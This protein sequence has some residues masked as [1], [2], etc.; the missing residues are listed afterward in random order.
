MT[1]ARQTDNDTYSA[2][3]VDIAL[4]S[5]YLEVQLTIFSPKNFQSWNPSDTTNPYCRTVSEVPCKSASSLAVAIV[6]TEY[7]VKISKKARILELKRRYLKITIMTPNTPYPSRKIRC[8]CA[9]TSQKTTKKIRSIRRIQGRP[10]RRIQAMEI[11]YSGRYRTWSL[12]QETP[13]TP[14][15]EE[16]AQKCGKV[17][18]WETAKYGKIWYDEDVHDLKS[19]ETEFPAIVFNDNLT[20][21]ETLFCEPTIS[22]LNNNEI[23]FRISFDES[24]D[25]DYIVVFDNNSFS[26][27]IISA[28][29]LKTD[30]ENDIEKV[31]VPSFPLPEPKVS[32]FDDLDFFRDFENEFSAIVYND[33]LTSKS[34]FLSKPTLK[35]QQIDEFNLKNETSLSEYDEVEQNVL[36]F[37]DLFPFN[38]IYPDDLMSGKDNDDNKID[39]IQ[40]SEGNENTQG[41]NNLLEGS[42]D[43]INKI[44]NE[45]S[46]IMEL[47][48]NIM[49][50]NYLVNGMLLNLIKN[51]YVPFGIPFDPKRYYK[52]GDCTRMLQRPMY[53]CFTLLNLEKLVSKNGYGVLDMGLPPRDLSTGMLK[54]KVYSLAELGGDYLILEGI[55]EFFSTFR[56]GE[57]VLDLD[58]T[59][60]Y[61]FRI[62]RARRSMSGGKFIC[63]L[64]IKYNKGNWRQLDSGQLGRELRRRSLLLGGVRHLRRFAAGRKSGALILGGQF[65]ARLA[66]H[67]GLLTE[68][69]LQG[70]AE[71][72]PVA[73][74]SGD[75]DEEM[76]QA[77]TPPPRTQGKRIFRLEEETVTSLSWMMD[78]AGVTYTRYSESP[79][80]YQRRVVRKRNDEPTTFAAPQRIDP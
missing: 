32:C 78:R 37:N 55:L 63:S 68:K 75:E 23:D 3:A 61:S 47:N 53:V 5:C 50:W 79:V 69:R 12:L 40:S 24:N 30:S 41:S 16:K 59:G 71:E 57:A 18:N 1:C 8:I 49:V 29:D 35:P 22:Y 21:N 28:N 19:V 58:T 36:Y 60:L 17:F 14:L 43:K 62:G 33:A 56:F 9:C 10:I 46:F 51:L 25:E 73:P 13:N 20:S 72:A 31:N 44:F 74:G 15:E 52:D 6:N 48:V 80:E 27:K 26:Y 34:N 76:P 39:I 4:Q 77:V 66:E 54:D 64:S 65:V 2:L 70:V 45:K 11:K 67:F 7:L 42:H 38:I